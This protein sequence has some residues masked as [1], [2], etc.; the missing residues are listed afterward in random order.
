M[1]N[2]GNLR[3]GRYQ[4]FE[5]F[6]KSMWPRWRR[7]AGVSLLDCLV[8]HAAHRDDVYSYIH[9]QM[10]IGFVCV[11]GHHSRPLTLFWPCLDL[12]VQLSEWYFWLFSL[13][14]MPVKRPACTWCNNL[15]VLASTRSINFTKTHDWQCTYHVWIPVVNQ[16]SNNA[17]LNQ[18]NTSL[19]H[20][21]LFKRQT[22]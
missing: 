20:V 9:G 16:G 8:I 11:S 7:Y 22:S 2:S 4:Y 10:C 15:I 21:V 5:L 18:T 12:L 13:C 14:K 19:W 3:D 17:L 6:G 1:R